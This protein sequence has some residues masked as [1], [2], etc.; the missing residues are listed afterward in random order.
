[1][2]KASA[3]ARWSISC[4]VAI[5]EIH[6][7][8][9]ELIHYKIK[10]NQVSLFF[11]N[12]Q[13][14]LN[15]STYFLILVVS[16]QTARTLNPAENKQLLAFIAL[17]AWG[18]MI[19]SL[20]VSRVVSQTLLPLLK[21]FLGTS[22]IVLMCATFAFAYL[23]VFCILEQEF[24]MRT[25]EGLIRLLFLADGGGIQMVLGLGDAPSEGTPFNQ[26]LLLLVGF[27]FCICVLNLFIAVHGRA[28]H[29][30]ILEASIIYERERAHMCVVAFFLPFWQGR[31]IP[32]CSLIG[33]ALVIGAIWFVLLL[34]DGLITQILAVLVLVV[35]QIV[36]SCILLQR[37][38]KLQAT[39]DP[40][41]S[42]LWICYPA[43]KSSGKDEEEQIRLDKMQRK[44]ADP[45]EI[46]RLYKRIDSL[47]ALVG[48]ANTQ[49]SV[50]GLE[51]PVANTHTQSSVRRKDTAMHV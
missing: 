39:G 16:F 21:S 47:E 38:W 14:W 32:N 6:D 18:H 26:V 29:D 33:L 42:Y 45:A 36:C 24:S 15:L 51:I 46:E 9:F 44:S 2:S 17:V 37:P 3:R 41:K 13:H 35:G 22:S 25:T 12:W 50:R 1:V 7:Q 4:A 28:Y 10:L 48:Q 19:A 11:C 40:D 8:V 5:R 31:P 34:Y 30:A 49:R 23:H 20:R 43:E 27:T